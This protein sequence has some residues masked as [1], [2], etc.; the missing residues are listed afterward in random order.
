MA[1]LLLLGVVASMVVGAIIALGLN[2][3]DASGEIGGIAF[4]LGACIAGL[5]GAA[6]SHRMPP[7]GRQY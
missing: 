1:K 7:P 5:I 3:V 4:V 2:A 6:V